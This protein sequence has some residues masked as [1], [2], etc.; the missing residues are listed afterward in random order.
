[1]LDR[2]SPSRLGETPGVRNCLCNRLR[3]RASHP[4]ALH[5]VNE[6]LLLGAALDETRPLHRSDV[7]GSVTRVLGQLPVLAPA[8]VHIAGNDR[9][10]TQNRLIEN[11]KVD[12]VFTSDERLCVMSGSLRAGGH[13]GPGLAI[14]EATRP[15]GR[16][17]CRHSRVGRMRT[18]SIGS[19]LL[20]R[21]TASEHP[22]GA[23]ARH[24]RSVAARPHR[25]HR[26]QNFCKS[27]HFR[28]SRSTLLPGL[29]GG[30]DTV[31][32]KRR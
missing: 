9:K 22:P 16:T 19:L 18:V 4:V 15:Q 13:R 21:N 26:W 23:P 6:G 1:M 8:Q 12:P 14:T 10:R 20:W 11:A 3:S 24:T 28:H 30:L 27:K 31:W 29:P 7:V 25:S 17:A 5:G 2:L 32:Y